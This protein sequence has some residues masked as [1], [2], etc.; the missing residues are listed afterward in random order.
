LL[1]RISCDGLCACAWRG[2]I[3]RADPSRDAKV[4]H[5]ARDVSVDGGHE[6]VMQVLGIS[7]GDG[8]EPVDFG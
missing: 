8:E 2:L 4:R 5:F 7:A 1:G 3:V 6:L